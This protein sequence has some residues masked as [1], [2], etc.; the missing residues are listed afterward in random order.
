MDTKT[1]KTNTNL[2]KSFVAMLAM[3][4]LVAS[5]LFFI[6]VKTVQAQEDQQIAAQ[7]Q[8]FAAIKKQ[9]RAAALQYDSAISQ[10]RMLSGSSLDSKQ[11]VE[12]AI[13]ILQRHRLTL[14]KGPFPKMVDMAINN[15]R[16][17][18]SVINKASNVG[19]EKLSK[20]IE[21]NPSMVMNFT[22]AK[23]VASAIRADLRKQSDYFK[24]LG[25]KLEAAKQ[26]FE[27]TQS[28]HRWDSLLPG[29]DNNPY[30][31]TFASYSLFD[32]ETNKRKTYPATIVP[33]S[34]ANITEP[35]S[36]AAVGALETALVA[37]AIVIIAAAAAAAAVV[38]KAYADAKAED[39]TDP[40]DGGVSDYK[41]CTD[42][43]DA[44]L[45]S[46][47]DGLGNNPPWWEV[48]GCWG[49]YALRKADCLLLPQ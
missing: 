12:R 33:A 6:S 7:K 37:A 29:I 32:A 44:K 5:Q 18:Q 3:F 38:I 4:A 45:D 36:L 16:F 13:S 8:K 20:Q 49:V 25:N 48:S 24:A 9:I 46:C 17:E 10:V 30:I 21:T 19:Y 42:N 1:Y 14:D 26:K 35:T 47:L 39:F 41:K 34:Y 11:N 22:G 28:V 43:A 40:K 23:D 27:S 2:Y 31:M 15:G